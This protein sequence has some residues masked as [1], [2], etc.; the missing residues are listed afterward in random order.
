MKIG[1][2]LCNHFYK[3]DGGVQILEWHYNKDTN[4]LTKLLHLLCIHE[5][6]YLKNEFKVGHFYTKRCISVFKEYNEN[7]ILEDKKFS[8][9]FNNNNIIIKKMNDV[10]I[11]RTFPTK[12]KNIYSQQYRYALGN[13]I[14]NFGDNI[15][16]SDIILP[17]M[18]INELII[19]LLIKDIVIIRFL[20]L[21]SIL[22][23]NILNYSFKNFN[24]LYSHSAYKN[25]PKNIIVSKNLIQIYDYLPIVLSVYF[26]YLIKL[27]PFHKLYYNIEKIV[28]NRFI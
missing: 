2:N 18:I 9:K 3:F 12:M 4:Y 16:Q 24:E 14:I 22:I 10:L 20:V 26:I 19:S 25:A 8:I 7:S 15:I 23:I 6:Y 13:Q 17:H 28:W 11:Y 21:L 5:N 27:G 1:I